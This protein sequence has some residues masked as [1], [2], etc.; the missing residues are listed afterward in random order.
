MCCCVCLLGGGVVVVVVVP[1]V[2]F[3]IEPASSFVSFAPRV[4][5]IAADHGLG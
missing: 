2:L 3:F 5:R 1:R 4:E